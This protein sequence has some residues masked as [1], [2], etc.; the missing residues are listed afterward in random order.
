MPLL[1]KG[2]GSPQ[3]QE[4]SRQ[5]HQAIQLLEMAL[6]QPPDSPTPKGTSRRLLQSTN[7][8]REATPNIPADLGSMFS[9]LDKLEHQ[10]T[11][12]E[13]LHQTQ[14]FQ[15]QMNDKWAAM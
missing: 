12:R 8:L 5:L 15:Q 2:Q 3:I 1:L 6:Q 11:N 13:V 9:E 4:P 14:Q 10:P 7:Q